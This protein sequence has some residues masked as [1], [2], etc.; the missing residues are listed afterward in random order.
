MADSKDPD[1]EPRHAIA[2]ARNMGLP[3]GLLVHT[4]MAPAEGESTPSPVPLFAQC[5]HAAGREEGQ[6]N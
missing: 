4:A 3:A 1:W 5:T 6:A 2:V